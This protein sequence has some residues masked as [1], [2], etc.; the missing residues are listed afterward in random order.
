MEIA[1]DGSRDPTHV[2][3]VIARV[4]EHVGSARRAYQGR[5][6][7][8]DRAGCSLAQLAPSSRSAPFVQYVTYCRDV[9]GTVRETSKRSLL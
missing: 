9:S 2:G 5:R 8:F 1:V 3:E 6:V 7:L 4:V